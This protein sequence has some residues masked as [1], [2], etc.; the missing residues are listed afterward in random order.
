MKRT[1]VKQVK[2][3]NDNRMR[4]ESL[5]DVGGRKWIKEQDQKTKVHCT[6]RERNS[7]EKLARDLGGQKDKM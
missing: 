1:K 5:K 3:E 4:P 7:M 6:D 2:A